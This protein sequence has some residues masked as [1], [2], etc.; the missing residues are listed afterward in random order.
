MTDDDQFKIRPGRI[1]TTRIAKSKSFADQ[2]LRAAQKAGHFT[3]K[4]AGGDKLGAGH[5]TFGRGRISFARQRLFNPARRVIVKARIV[6]HAGRAFRS[7]PMSAHMAYLARDGVSLDGEEAIFFGN[8]TDQIDDRNFSGR[9]HADR[10]HFRFIISPEDAADMTDLRAFTRDLA[11]QME[12]DLGTSLD[13]V[14]V[15]H[16]NTDNPH[17]HLLVRGVAADGADLVISRDYISRGLRSRAEELV[18]IE[19]GPKP[20]HEIRSALAR[21]VQAERWTKLDQQIR[22]AANE[23]GYIDL[24]P[25]S[26][27]DHDGETRRLMIGRLQRLQKM[28]LAQASGPGAW[29]LDLGAERTLRDLAQRADII[30]T[31]H[32]AFVARGEQRSPADFAVGEIAAGGPIIGKLVGNGLR[33]ELTGEAYAIIDGID[34]RAHHIKLPGIEA[35]VKAPPLGGIVELRRFGKADEARPTLVLTT[36]S[37]FDLQAQIS[38]DGATW[39]DH[40]LVERNPIPLSSGGFGGEVRQALAAR[41]DHLVD[42][43]LAKRQGAQVTFQR[44]LL[45]TLQQRELTRVAEGLSAEIK[46]SNIPSESGGQI[47]GIYRKRLVLASGRFAMIETGLGFQLVPWSKALETRLGQ[48]VSGISRTGSGIYWTNVRQRGLGV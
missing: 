38:A 3:G 11:R 30:K 48:S 19:L 1:R 18:G 10:H 29:G 34:G 5:S 14:A 42:Q 9:C 46:R 20:E 6:R 32:Q 47:Q 7:T 43:G 22:C 33:D 36:R 40:R 37:D 21:D 17:V 26:T 24:R 15:D 8:E 35:F 39:L 41:V 45:T 23:T 12:A 4:S 13:W 31:M 28:G 27:S 16:W 44:N 25:R 2:V